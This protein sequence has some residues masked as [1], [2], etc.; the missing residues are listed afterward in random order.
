[1]L[2]AGQLEDINKKSP[3][4]ITINNHFYHNSNLP[5]L[6]NHNGIYLPKGYG[7]YNSILLKYK[8]KKINLSVE[9]TISRIIKKYPYSLTKKNDE[10]SKLNDTPLQKKNHPSI[11]KLNNIGAYLETASLKIGYGN[12]NQWCKEDKGTNG[13]FASET[14]PQCNR[15]CYKFLE[16]GICLEF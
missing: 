10:F 12:W 14:C 6:E 2:F 1:M 9:P 11:L 8:Y 3:L 13:K 4:S 5:N 16:C 15:H 7:A